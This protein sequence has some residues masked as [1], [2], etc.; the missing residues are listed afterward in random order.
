MMDDVCEYLI[1]DHAWRGSHTTLYSEINVRSMTTG[2]QHP[3][4]E[5]LTLGSGNS[6]EP[7]TDLNSFR[8]Y[9]DFCAVLAPKD[10]FED[11]VLQVWDWR[12]GRRL[13]VSNITHHFLPSHAQP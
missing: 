12:T 11:R 3:L 4:A 10:S 8:I 6:L 7:I 13:L 9:E 2:L 5:T 1:A